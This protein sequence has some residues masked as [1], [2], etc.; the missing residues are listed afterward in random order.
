MR[1]LYLTLGLASL[2]L[3]TGG[4]KRRHRDS[5][6]SAQLL[7]STIYAGDP[8]AASHFVSGFYD[9]EEKSWRWTGK[10]F[11]VNL[12]PPLHASQRGAQLILHLAVPDAIIQSLKSVQLSAS[13]QGLKLDPQTFDKPGQYTYVRDVPA[14]KLQSDVARVDFSLDHTMPAAKPDIRQ[15]GVIVSEVGLVAK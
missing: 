5:A 4:C 15:L 2:L 12:S 8:N 10:D 14:D 3:V 13:V 7:A 1:S 6:Q 11:A 9:I